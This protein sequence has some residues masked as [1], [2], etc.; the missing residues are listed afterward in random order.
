MGSSHKTKSYGQ[1]EQA[2]RKAFY[3]RLRIICEKMVGTGYF[4]L[5]PESSLRLLYLHRYPPIKVIPHGKRAMDAKEFLVYKESLAQLLSNHYINTLLGERI[6]YARF[7][8]DTLILIHF[9]QYRAGNR[10]KGFARLCAAFAPYFT[11]TEWFAKQRSDIIQVMSINDLQLYDFYRGTVRFS[12]HRMAIEKFGG[13]NEIHVHRLS[14]STKLHEIDGKKRAIVRMGVPSQNKVDEFEWIAVRPSELG[15][16]DVD[17]EIALPVYAQQHALDRFEERAVFWSGYVQL[18]LG[19]VFREGK[20]KS[21][22]RKSYVLLECYLGAHKVGYF[23]I[24]LHED[25]WLIRTFLF[26]T[27]EGTPEGNRLKKLTH[28]Q[29]ADKKYLMIDLM[30][31][32]LTYDIASDKGLRKLF[33]KAGCGS[34]LNYAD[35]INKYGD[36]PLKNPDFIY[37]YLSTI[38]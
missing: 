29:I 34:L 14:H 6:S 16:M 38:G 11:T 28:L 33:N 17:G 5:L 31:A 24:S 32:F 12:F 35:V 30:D 27:N 4:E 13:S 37:R 36:N 1:K 3:H 9:V 20:A 10:I 15:M 8:T 18:Y 22:V 26:L 21:I 7:L 25:K 19:Y 2:R 23:V